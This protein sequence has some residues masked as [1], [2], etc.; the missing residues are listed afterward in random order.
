MNYP[1]NTPDAHGQLKAFIERLMR[2]REEAK[3]INSDIREIYAE[4]KAAGFDK[5]VLGKVVL[6]VE[7]RAEKP[8]A[9]S[10]ADTLFDLYLSA[11]D[12]SHAHAREG[13]E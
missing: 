9:V 4:A 7:R 12:G 10:E 6:Y 11:F 13:S 5:T 3:A 2:M 8:E 1:S